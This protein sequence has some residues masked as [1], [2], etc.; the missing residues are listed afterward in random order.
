VRVVLSGDGGEELFGGRMLDGLVRSLRVARRFARLPR[1]VRSPLGRVLG[2]TER[3]RRMSTAPDDYVLQLGLGGHDLFS[4][5]ER[6]QLLRDHGLVRPSVRQDVLAPFYEGID[7]DP[8]NLALHGYLRSAL[9]EASLPRADRTAAASGLDVRFPLLDSG[10]MEAAA[11]L[12]GS[13]KVRRVGGS[14]H[15]RWPLRALLS[16]V[17]PA[18]LVDRPKRGLPVPLGGWLAG[19]GRLFLED[20]IRRLKDDPLQLWRAET[21]DALHRDVRRSNAAGNRLWTL[22][23]LD[24]WLRTVSSTSAS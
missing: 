8:I 22:F 6:S 13:A 7:T 17:L 10:V 19:A 3:G 4:A 12:P 23:I 2:R 24:A 9:G 21:L 1:A 5:E 18:T 15:T 16:G 11:A 14:L 20:R